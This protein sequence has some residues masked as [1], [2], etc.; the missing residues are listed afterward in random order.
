MASQQLIQFAMPA[1]D[2]AVKLATLEKRKQLLR[3]RARSKHR[4]PAQQRTAAASSSKYPPANAV[5]NYNLPIDRLANRLKLSETPF[6][7]QFIF[8]SHPPCF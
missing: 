7:R 5:P 4:S 8:P 2:P 6:S 1:S 3:P